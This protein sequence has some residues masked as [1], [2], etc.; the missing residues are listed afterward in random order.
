[1]AR[2]GQRAGMSPEGAAIQPA[3]AVAD[4]YRVTHRRALTAVA[5]TMTALAVVIASATWAYSTFDFWE[6]GPLLTSI[7]V[8]AAAAGGA[9]Y[10]AT[11]R[12]LLALLVAVV[13]AS[14]HFVLLLAITLAR[15]EG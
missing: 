9:F 4:R 15:W 6:R 5:L 14:A 11:R 10:A 2:L 3:P 12:R 13:L 8:F 1:L 7:C